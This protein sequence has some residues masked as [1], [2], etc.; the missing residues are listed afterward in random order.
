MKEAV[1]RARQH[2]RA[3]QRIASRVLCRW[4]QRLAEQAPGQRARAKELAQPINKPESIPRNIRKE[5]GETVAVGDDVTKPD[6][7]DIQPKDVFTPTTKDMGVYNLA[8]T[9]KDFKEDSV[10]SNQGYDTVNNLSQ[11]LIR[12]DGG[13]ESGPKGKQ[14]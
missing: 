2:T 9:G 13:G 3:R 4:R 12:T 1:A 10:E 7:K 6:R 8:E 11:Y 5:M 14:S